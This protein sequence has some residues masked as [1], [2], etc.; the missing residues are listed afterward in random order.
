MT[1]KVSSA[2]KAIK[3][4]VAA[5]VARRIE[6]ENPFLSFLRDQGSSIP[7]AE[8]GGIPFGPGATEHGDSTISDIWISPLHEGKGAGSA[9]I[10]ALEQ[11]IRDRGYGDASIQ[12]AAANKRALHLY[13]HLG[14]I[15]HWL[16]PE[17]DPILETRLKKVGLKKQ[18]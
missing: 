18:F 7:V 11:V 4:L 13:R 5:E 17:F 10:K 2:E 1:R 12:V 14:Y 16:R 6:G 8:Y 9:L 3:P 15:E